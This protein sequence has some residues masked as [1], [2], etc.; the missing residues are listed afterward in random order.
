MNVPQHIDAGLGYFPAVEKLE[1]A[2]LELPQQEC[3]VVHTFGPGLYVRQVTLKA[4]TFAIGHCQKFEHLNVMLTGSVTMIEPDGSHF[5]RTAPMVFIGKPGRKVGYIH[6]DS[7]WLN[8]YATNETDVEK[9]EEMYLDKSA[10]FLESL[11]LL[12]F[13]RSE[14]VKD[15]QDALAEVGF[16]ESLV[17]LQ[18]E[19]TTDQIAFPAGSYKVK[20]GNSSI[21]GK[22]LI[23]VGPISVGEVIAPARVGGMRTPAG[24]FTNHAKTPNAMMVARGSDIDLVATRDI[25]GCLGGQDGEEITVDYRQALAVNLASLE[26]A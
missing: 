11:K 14:D 19:N 9:L 24:R 21:E 18:S 20:V 7:V 12:T 6:E 4:D 15:F 13:N 5:V 17:R 1:E 22:G 26:V 2:M 3:P 16:H 8:I 10:A 23:A 25:D